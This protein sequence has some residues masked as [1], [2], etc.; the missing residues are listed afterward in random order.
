[1]GPGVSWHW[2]ANTHNH[3]VPSGAALEHCPGALPST[4]PCFVCLSFL[5]PSHGSR[6]EEGWHT[7]GAWRRVL[8][9]L[10]DA[11]GEGPCSS[12]EV[13]PH[14]GL[15]ACPWLLSTAPRQRQ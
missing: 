10:R 2:E 9:Y 5:P 15:G 1:M 4:L 13:G 7:A 8:Q 6:G 14:P 3:A 11:V 12:G